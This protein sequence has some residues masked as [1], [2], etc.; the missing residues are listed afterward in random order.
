MTQRAQ[1]PVRGWADVPFAPRRVPFYYGWVILVVATIGT[2]MSIP[3]QTMGVSVFTDA[4]LD[5]TGLSR[6]AVSNAYLVGTLL[7]GLSLPVVGTLVD[8]FGVRAMALS[9]TALLSLTLVFLSGVDVISYSVG[10]SPWATG[11]LLTLGFFALRLSGQGTLTMVSRT[12]L[13]RWFSGR[14][15]LAAGISG[16]FVGFGF[17]Y[18]P[19]FL[20]DWIATATWR[21]AW[22][23]MAALIAVG[24]GSV[25][26]FFF[27]DDPESCGLELEG[28]VSDESGSPPA[29]RA[30]TRPEA[31]RTFSFWSVSYTL[32]T[33]ALILTGVTFHI[34]DLG[35]ASGLDPS[36]AVAVF[37][38]LAVVSTAVGLVGGAVGDRVAVRSLMVVMMAAQAAGIWGAADLAE[39]SLAFVL[40]FGASSGLFGPLSTIAYPRLFGRRHLGAIIGAEMMCLVVAS[41]LGPSLLAWSRSAFGAYDPALLAS[42]VL[43]ATA[44]F[45]ALA[46]RRPRAD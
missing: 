24:M 15:G 10:A 3:G 34:V 38:P 14:R 16:V 2:L 33:Q 35:S 39:R 12:M 4:L 8:R 31:L 17:G 40:G 46:V 18:A 1:G 25:A 5:A 9:A 41:S 28:E 36:Q 43:P 29:E 13:G 23:Q 6:L 32:S 26:F 21:G 27:R 19:Q 22:L 37:L 44:A 11:G 20:H 7:S 30:F 45:G 42:I